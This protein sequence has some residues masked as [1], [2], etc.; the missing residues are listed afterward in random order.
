MNEASRTFHDDITTWKLFPHYQ[1]STSDH[2]FPPQRANNVEL[3]YSLFFTCIIYWTNN[4]VVSYLKCFK[5]CLMSAQCG[6]VLS[7]TSTYF[8]I[9]TTYCSKNHTTPFFILFISF[10]FMCRAH[11]Y[12]EICITYK[13]KLH[14]IHNR[15]E[16]EPDKPVSTSQISSL[17]QILMNHY[18]VRSL[19]GAWNRGI[20]L[21]LPKHLTP[22]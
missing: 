7:F 11:I 18:A 20:L 19:A 16:T 9:T 2:W 1:E 22:Q 3:W 15:N 13:I 5:F 14:G 17:H 12:P 8:I 21:T 6:T 10:D 4:W